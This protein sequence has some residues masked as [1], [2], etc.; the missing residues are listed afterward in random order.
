MSEL[1]VGVRELKIHLSEYLQHVKAGQT[2]VITERGK[3]VGRII[4]IGQPLEK[5]IQSLVEAGMADW[6]G[7]RFS[8]G[9]A[10]VV[11]RGKGL[12]SDLVVEG[13]K[14]GFSMRPKN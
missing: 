3:P 6:N 8:P 5:R 11:N 13:R 9:E 12:V 10:I 4:P 7:Q 14:A 1:N 2:L